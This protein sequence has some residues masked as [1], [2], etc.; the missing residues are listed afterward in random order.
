M[1]QRQKCSSNFVRSLEISSL[2][3]I[4]L[5]LLIYYTELVIRN[6]SDYGHYANT[7]ETFLRYSAWFVEWFLLVPETLRRTSLTCG[8]LLLGLSFLPI[9]R[10]PHSERR[11]LFTLSSPCIFWKLWNCRNKL[12][13]WLHRLSAA[14]TSYNSVRLWC[15]GCEGKPVRIPSRISEAKCVCQRC[16]QGASEA[17]VFNYLKYTKLNV[18]RGKGNIFDYFNW[19]QSSFIVQC[20]CI[21]SFA[22]DDNLKFRILRWETYRM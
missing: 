12:F 9:A 18:R 17:G 4:N 6:F 3:I 16:S 15:S 13:I 19:C 1:Q 7:E 8:I 20:K 21:Q 2:D 11:A 22:G 10:F 5:Y 14:V